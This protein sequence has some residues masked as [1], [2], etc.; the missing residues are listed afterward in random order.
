MSKLIQTDKNV[1][2]ALA[3]AK[4]LIGTPY[5]WWT[6]DDLR[7]DKGPFWVHNGS[8]PSRKIILAQS[9]TCTGLI[10]LMRR[11]IGLSISGISSYFSNINVER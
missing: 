6:G 4:S 1:D 11:K 3:Y 8:V 2:I 7:G 10:N 9:C 5:E